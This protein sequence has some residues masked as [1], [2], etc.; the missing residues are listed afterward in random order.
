MTSESGNRYVGILLT[1]IGVFAALFG[2]CGMI[3]GVGSTSEF[4]WAEWVVW[5]ILP[6]VAGVACIYL[7]I[8]MNESEKW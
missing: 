8:R 5:G 4:E 3:I 2:G 1:I 7:G 6:M